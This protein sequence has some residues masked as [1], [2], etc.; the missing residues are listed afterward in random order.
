MTQGE[1][2]IN[3]GPSSVNP[4][5]TLIKL[6]RIKQWSKNLLVFAAFLFTG[7]FSRG[8][9][10]SQVLLTFAAMCLASSGTYIFNDIADVERDRVHPTKKYRPL[11]SGQVSK[12][13]GFI[14][15][16]LLIL[17]SLGISWL[18][19]PLC[20]AI[21][22]AYLAL[23]VLYNIGLKRAPVADVYCISFGFVLR[24]ALGAAALTVTISPWLLLCTG[25]L[26]LMLG[27]GKRR[28]EFIQQGEARAESR[29]SLAHY[30]QL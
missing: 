14:I 13:S 30:N 25:A 18:V 19:N 16:I 8:D 22:I 12:Q 23:Q 24:A 5:R 10:W 3:A 20:S 2:K 6:F 21:V 26:A 28:S 4:F 11:A 27:F 7:G 29:E 1:S 9:A 15:G 17:A